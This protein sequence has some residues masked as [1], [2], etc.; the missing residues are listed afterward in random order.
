MKLAD[1]FEVASTSTLTK[2]DK[3][4]ANK[5]R[6]D[7]SSDLSASVDKVRDAKGLD[8]KKVALRNMATHFTAGGKEKFLKVID[9]LPTP[10]RADKYAYDTLL[11]G[12]GSG[13]LKNH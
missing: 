5:K 10:E 13:A 6:A 9:T 3:Q 7:K 11:K 8:A 4:D 1:L 12:E 2:A